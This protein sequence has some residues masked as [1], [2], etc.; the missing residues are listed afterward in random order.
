MNRTPKRRRSRQRCRRGWW[1]ALIACIVAFLFSAGMLMRDVAWVVKERWEREQLSMQ[2]R[3]EWV[4]A[5]AEGKAALSA[6]YAPSGNLA[7]YD[8][9][10]QEN[11]DLAGWLSIGD[12][13]VDL[14]VMYTPLETEYY[15]HRSFDGGY[16][17]SGSLFLG[18][19]WQQE[20]DYAII[21]GHNMKDGSMFGKLDRYQSLEYAK[22]H[23]AIYFDTLTQE[24]E[25]TVWA[26]FYSQAHASPE[27]DGFP[28][29][30][31]TDL[32]DQ[33]SFEEYLRQVRAR[34]LYDTGADI[35][36]GDRLLVLSTC[37][38]HREEGRFVVVAYQKEK[39]FR[40]EHAAV[41]FYFPIRQ[42]I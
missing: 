9:L 26:A 40:V 36:Y 24:R 31:Y 15:L 37:S 41:T 11:H 33:E 3:K 13:G 2:V 7:A 4:K 1:W 20:G 22:E 18:E 21:Y 6:K 19:G 8:R 35:R 23:P 14:P 29:Y 10:W 25:Y 5:E 16:A 30:Q 42:Y 27:T 32:P 38:Y 12:L 39:S 34:A 17:H 28:Y